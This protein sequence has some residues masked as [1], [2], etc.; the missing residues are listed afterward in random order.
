MALV[1]GSMRCAMWLAA[2]WA[3]TAC[4]AEAADP[5]ACERVAR[6]AMADAR[7]REAGRPVPAVPDAF[8]AFVTD[9]VI[10]T[11]AKNT[12]SWGKRDFHAANKNARHHAF[13]TVA[14]LGGYE[15]GHA[16]YTLWRLKILEVARGHLSDPDRLWATYLR[17]KDAVL[18]EIRRADAGATVKGQLRGTLLPVFTEPVDQEMAAAAQEAALS[19][20]LLVATPRDHS[21]FESNLQRRDQARQAAAP[22][23]SDG[24]A[25]QWK[26]R[27]QAEGGPA[28]V[29]AWARVFA[30]LAESL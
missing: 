23:A 19:Q 4:V 29:A 7:S 8:S 11:A 2:L 25:V 5:S 9:L 10:R 20:A 6:Q 24:Y 28:L 16:S 18:D 30:D 1:E 17:H 21:C 3:G 12:F 15:L 13:A 14:Q 27:R 26:L 22:F